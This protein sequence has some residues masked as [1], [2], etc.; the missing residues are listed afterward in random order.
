[1]DLCL[2]S[3]LFKIFV[4]IADPKDGWF[5]YTFDTFLGGDSPVSCSQVSETLFRLGLPRDPSSS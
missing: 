3:K 4:I 2:F 1:M 5:V